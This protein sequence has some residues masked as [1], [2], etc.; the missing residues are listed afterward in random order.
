MAIITISRGTLSGGKATAECLAELLDYPCVGREI[1]QDAARAIGVPEE[2]LQKSFHA[3][4]G[5]WQRITRERRLYQLAVKTALVE[6]CAGG[7]LVYHGFAGQFLLRDI[8]AVCAV[9]LIA[10]LEVRVSALIDAHHGM[11]VDAA[12]EFIRGVD[13]DRR[14]WAELMYDANIED[15][16][17][18][19]LTVNLE[20]LS[21]DAACAV[22]AEAA[23]QPPFDVTAEVRE[24]LAAIA[25][26]CRR[27]LAEAGG[28]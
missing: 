23:S 26:D 12:Q 3:P 13:Q 21:L 5:F 17:L 10:P 11:G 27:Q 18:Y 28:T 22:I 24:Q 2:R 8:P 25:A 19:D 1:V 15:P 4:A 7:N 14:R 6:Q 9:R 16:A 20:A